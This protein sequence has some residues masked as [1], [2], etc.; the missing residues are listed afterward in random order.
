M[1]AAGIIYIEAVV[2]DLERPALIAA[3]EQ[4]DECLSAAAG[5]RT[6]IRLGFSRSLAAIQPKNTTMVVIASL[7]ADVARG[8]SLSA[9]EARWRAQLSSMP[10][11]PACSMFLCTVFRHIARNAT[12]PSMVPGSDTKER[13]LR[14]NLLAA[15]LSHDT[16]VAIIDIDRAFAHLGARE[17]RTDYRLSG[18]VAAEVAAHTI[19]GGILSAGLDEVVAADVLQRAIQFHGALWQVNTLV[20]RRLGRRQ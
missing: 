14:L 8:E 18:A 6:E 15:E 11:E 9:T 5:A 3:A 17:L 10:A 16:G 7:L 13:I 19:V 4:L 20:N 1:S 12:E 2:D